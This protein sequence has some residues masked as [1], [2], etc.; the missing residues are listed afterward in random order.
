AKLPF[1]GSN[2]ES[3]YNESTTNHAK[4]NPPSGAPNGQNT[5]SHATPPQE[6]RRAHPRVPDRARSRA[7]DQGLR[8]QSLAASRPDHDPARVPARA[9]SLR[10]LHPSEARH[11]LNSSA[12]RPGAAG[13]AQTAPRGRRQVALPVPVRARLADDGVQLPEAHQPSLRGR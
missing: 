12:D 4:A 7:A 11:A 6:R 1:F 13:T 3:H 2:T 9:A 5:E 10:G 8:E